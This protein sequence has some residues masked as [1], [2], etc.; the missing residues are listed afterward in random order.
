[1]QSA[2][3]GPVSW[4]Y[5]IRKGEHFV[6]YEGGFAT[7]NQALEAGVIRMKEYAKESGDGGLRVATLIDGARPSPEPFDPTPN[8]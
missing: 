8:S 5:E 7:R 2:Y 4:R 6:S 1:M 3:N